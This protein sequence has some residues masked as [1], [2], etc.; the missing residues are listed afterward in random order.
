MAWGGRTPRRLGPRRTLRRFGAGSSQRLLAALSVD[1]GQRGRSC[2][3]VPFE[4]SRGPACSPSF[5]FSLRRCSRSLAT[6]T[7]AEPLSSPPLLPLSPPAL[8][9]SVNRTSTFKRSRSSRRR[10]SS[11]SLVSATRSSRALTPPDLQLPRPAVSPQSRP[12]RPPRR[13]HGRT[14]RRDDEC[15]PSLSS[16]SPSP[17]PS[18]RLDLLNLLNLAA[19]FESAELNIEYLFGLFAGV[20][21]T[22][23]TSILGYPSAQTIQTLMVEP[24]LVYFSAVLELS[25]DTIGQSLPVQVD[26]T[27][28]WNDDLKMISYDATFRRFPRASRPSPRA[29]RSLEQTLTSPSFSRSQRPGRS[30]S[31]ASR[32]SSPRSSA[33][34]TTRR[35][36]TARP[37]CRA[38]RRARSARRRCS[39]ARAPTS[40]TSRTTSA[41]S[42]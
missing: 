19:A 10:A 21:N 33:R 31:T 26:V 8:Q 18:S 35:R 3:R 13:R 12:L 17:S 15:V 32:R 29:A 9:P 22:S 11:R 34:R 6:G 25:Y 24:P 16:P 36:R 5:P 20:R 41:T 27:T 4:A 7:C 42:S 38:R 14:S 30:S 37:S 40:S 39:T 23:S 2:G 1:L 28:A